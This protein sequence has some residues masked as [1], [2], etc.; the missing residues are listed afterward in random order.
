MNKCEGVND[1]PSVCT[2]VTRGW[3]GMAGCR[4]DSR[5]AEAEDKSP[6]ASSP[7]HDNP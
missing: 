6:S 1:R 3:E 7:P 5:D 2:L 4:L